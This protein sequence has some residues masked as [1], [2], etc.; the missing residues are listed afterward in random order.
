M[1]NK[2]VYIFSFPFFFC[3]ITYPVASKI[4]K[5]F[6]KVPLLGIAANFG[7]SVLVDMGSRYFYTSCS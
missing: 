3:R 6:S 1:A 7:E 2:K 5:L 4:I